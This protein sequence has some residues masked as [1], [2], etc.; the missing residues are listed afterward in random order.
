[1]TQLKEAGSTTLSS[2]DVAILTASIANQK[3][4]ED[5]TIF[6]I[7]ELTFVADYFVV[8]SGSNERQIKAIADEIKKEMK[9]QG[10]NI[11]GMEG[12]TDL[13]WVLIDLG[14]VVIHIFDKTTRSFYDFDL[15]WGDAPKLPCEFEEIT[16][17]DDEMT[18]S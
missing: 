9:K 4:A 16:D 12:N 15:L 11:L 14:D 2:K 5:I 18:L 10:V 7:G 13:K 6:K 1:M 8:C 3:K 17:E